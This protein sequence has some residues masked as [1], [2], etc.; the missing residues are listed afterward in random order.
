MGKASVYFQLSMNIAFHPK[1]FNFMP[2]K[3]TISPDGFGALGVDCVF[4]V[5]M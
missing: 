2:F 5:S 1:S 4:A 3:T